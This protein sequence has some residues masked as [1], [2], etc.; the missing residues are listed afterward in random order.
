IAKQVDFLIKN[1][2]IDLVDTGAYTI[3][4]LNHPVGKRGTDAIN[5]SDTSVIKHALLLHAS[6]LGRR[7]WFY[8]NPYD[9]NYVRAEDYELWCR[10]YKYSRFGR[11]YEHLYVIREGKV[12]VANYAASMKTLRK[13]FLI[14][15]SGVL[16]NVSL[17][18]QLT[19]TYIKTG[20]YYLMGLIRMQDILTA[21]RN[22]PLTVKEKE[23]VTEEIRKIQLID[24]FNS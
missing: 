18:W 16:S 9:S 10:T 8:N 15:G 1:P 6:V 17:Y 11:I 13:I 20:I 2:E 23:Y 12:N 22:T 19:K 7:E 21:K 4:E 3:N 5:I 14:Y 24:V